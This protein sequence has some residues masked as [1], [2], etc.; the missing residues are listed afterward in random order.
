MAHSVASLSIPWGQ[1][2]G[3]QDG[4]Y[5]LVWP[6]D[7]SQSATALLAAGEL[8]MPLRGLI[9]LAASQ[10]SD[11]SFH[12]KFMI[13]GQIPPFVYDAQQLDEYSFPVILAYRLSAAKALQQFDPR[14]WC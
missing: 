2:E 14:P 5:H 13:D 4:G 9:Y 7:M 10:S 3:D 12:Q 1:I 6:R 8:D 11:G